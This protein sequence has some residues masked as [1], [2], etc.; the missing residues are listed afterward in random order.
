V[1]QTT[2]RSRRLIAATLGAGLLATATI[3]PAT[4]APEAHDVAPGSLGVQLPALTAERVAA[5]RDAAGRADDT[6]TDEVVAPDALRRSAASRTEHAFDDYCGD[7]GTAPLDLRSATIVEVS[8]GVGYEF[9]I[10]TCRPITVAQLASGIALQIRTDANRNF[11][12]VITSDAANNGVRGLV[13]DL[14]QETVAYDGAGYFEIGTQP[15]LGR[16]AGIDFPASAIGGARRFHFGISAF[17]GDTVVDRMPELGEPVGHIPNSSACRPIPAGLRQAVTAEP[18]RLDVALAAARRAGLVPVG[19]HESSGSFEVLLADADDAAAVGRLPGVADVEPSAGF[20]RAAGQTPITQPAATRTAAAANGA[21]WWRRQVQADAAGRF[22]GPGVTIAVID[23]G[24]DGTRTEFGARVAAGFDALRG[25]AIGARANSSR[26]GHGTSV[27][28]VAAAAAGA[29]PAGIATG[30]TIRPYQVFD[31]AGCAGA[32]AIA[33]AVDR[34]VTDGADVI[35]LSLAGRGRTAGPLAASLTR[36]RDAGVLV[37]AAAGNDDALRVDYA[38]ADHPATIAVAATND[39]GQRASYSNQASWVEVAAPGGQGDTPSTGIQ[40]LAPGAGYHVMNG[41]SFAA[42]IAA[43]TAAV[44]M[45]ATNSS[46]AQ[47]RT[48]LGATSRDLGA[49]GRDIAFGHG[50]LDVRRL[51]TTRPPVRDLEVTCRPAPRGAFRDVTDDT[52]VHA[53]AIDCLAHY[54]VAGGYRDG[55]FGPYDEVNRGQMATFVANLILK[56]G[57]TLPAAGP[58][59]EGPTDIAGT[60]HETNIRRLVAAGIVGGYDDGTY[61]P[62]APVRRDQ[63]A[64]F[65]SKALEHRLGADLVAIDGRFPDVASTNTHRAAIDK[66]ATA[67]LA[68]GDASGRYQPAG[69]VRRE[70]M[71]SFLARTVAYLVDEGALAPR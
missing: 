24:V 28:G 44:Y 52:T 36:A 27:A 56:T 4:A 69:N 70:Q 16:V 13:L 65:L 58:D 55:T 60:Q 39:A 23:D 41:T 34:A 51:L 26:G 21:D 64:T 37:I 22:T 43:G 5:L 66:S 35:N 38:P 7:A 6:A 2:P 42:P 49:P 50:L 18:G 68:G 63:M 53:A 47:T 8:A 3:A 61:K 29:Q 33:T 59:R 57:G 20:T 48:A 46:A 71:G 45:E 32:S 31:F 62:N 54:G 1:T 30:A 11:A 12:A 19:I 9:E 14:D 15:G 17:D 25:T 67:G 40:T 10:E